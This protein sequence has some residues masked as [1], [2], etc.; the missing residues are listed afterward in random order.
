MNLNKTE[1]AML[2]AYKQGT[3]YKGTNTQVTPGGHIYLFGNNI[4]SNYCG[5]PSFTLAGYP[6][7][8]TIRR[9]NAV[10]AEY[11]MR[12]AIRKG[13]VTLIYHDKAVK[14]LDTSYGSWY[15]L[16]DLLA[17]Y[18]WLKPDKELTA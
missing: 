16:K 8:T 11:N 18:S 3:R 13:V 4:V 17:R 6:T 2:A 10:L 14:V 1:Q 5:L 12:V 9:I 7:R 15:Q